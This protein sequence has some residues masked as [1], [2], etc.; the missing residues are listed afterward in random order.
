MSQETIPNSIWTLSPSES[1]RSAKLKANDLVLAWAI[2]KDSGQPRYIFELDESHRGAKCG[3]LCVSCK[4]PLTAVNV[5]KTE[6][7]QR[8]H[9]KHP[10]G[11][12]RESCLVLSARYA[13]AQQ[14]LEQGFIELPQRRVSSRIVGLSGKIYEAWE[15]S[16]PERVKVTD[17]QFTD[18]ATALLT[19]DDGRKILVE[20]TG[21]LSESA[22]TE[23]SPIAAISIDIGDDLSIAGMSPSEL[24][25]RMTLLWAGACWH[26]HWADAELLEKA[27]NEARENAVNELD[28]L[29]D[30]GTIHGI[31]SLTNDQ[32]S[33]T[34][35]HLEVKK[36]LEQEKRIHL[37]ELLARVER[38]APRAGGYVREKRWP[39]ELVT[40]HEVQLEKR[41]G[42][43]IP[44]V[45]AKID[46]AENAGQVY[47]LLIEVTVTN[48]ITNERLQRIRDANLPTLEIDISRMGGL[49][50]R[51]EL[52]ELVVDELVAKRW[53]HHPKAVHETVKLEAEIDAEVQRLVG[54]EISRAK[55]LEVPLQEWV[56][57]FEKTYKEHA[58]LR[59]QSKRLGTSLASESELQ[60]SATSERLCLERLQDCSYALGLYGYPEANRVNDYQL[61]SILDRL[62]SI[63]MNSAVGYNLDTCWQVIN[64]MNMDREESRT[65]HTLFLIAINQYKPTLTTDQESK[66]K[67]W[68]SKVVGSIKGGGSDYLRS[69][70]YDALL[71]LLFPEMKAALATLY[72]TR[73][74][75][76]KANQSYTN[77]GQSKTNNHKNDYAREGGFWLKGRELEEWKRKYPQAAKIWFGE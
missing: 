51:A 47:T 26:S 67:D 14:L 34:L 61:A 19:L 73:P 42:R 70:K 59:V 22:G 6:Y 38:E 60:E 11:A 69:T 18:K 68:R 10:K 57:R 55:S 49:V 4:L 16:Q 53:L 72:G 37:P 20:L 33:E 23:G 24:R 64:T 12:Q 30:D 46:D 1:S 27:S 54:R 58:A 65:W 50:T 9:F 7:Q 36:I 44:D 75:I 8:P 62:F 56:E 25:E 66:V 15:F 63:K 52:V 39:S 77:Y 21:G 41:L 40:L 3:C 29:I 48:T 13:I 5:A 31:E 45:V 32:K 71:C 76:A 28:W 74:S 35:L 2:D 43:V 17:T